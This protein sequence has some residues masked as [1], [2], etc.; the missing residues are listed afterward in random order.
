MPERW[1]SRSSMRP[2][3]AEIFQSFSVRPRG[4]IGKQFGLA[5]LRLTLAKLLWNFVLSAAKESW[6]WNSEKAFISGTSGRCTSTPAWS[7][8]EG[9]RHGTL[10][11]KQQKRI[12]PIQF[13]VEQ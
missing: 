6:D 9:L 4:C 10:S 1:L 7:V 13:N 2:H 11:V 3:N 5:V 8:N 12:Y